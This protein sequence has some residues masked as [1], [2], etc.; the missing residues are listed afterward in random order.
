MVVGIFQNL[1]R[2]TTADLDQNLRWQLNTTTDVIF[3]FGP[4]FRYVFNHHT[5][6]PLTLGD[7]VLISA[8][9]LVGCGIDHDSHAESSHQQVQ[10]L[11]PHQDEVDQNSDQKLRRQLKMMTDA[12]TWSMLYNNIM[13]HAMR[14]EEKL[15]WGARGVSGGGPGS[16]AKFTGRCMFGLLFY[17]RRWH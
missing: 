13:D 10:N 9:F 12:A 15:E 1:Q 11:R 8:L 5:P 6:P 17:Q 2:R 16:S 3:C 14:T 7:F 4:L